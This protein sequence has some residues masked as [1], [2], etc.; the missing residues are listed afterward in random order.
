MKITNAMNI[1]H[2]GLKAAS[3]RAANSAHNVANS[4]TDGFDP[5]RVLAEDVEPGGVRTRVEKTDQPHAVYDRDGQTVE[6][7]N[8]DIAA[9]MVEQLQA[10]HAFKANIRMIQTVDSM[11]GSLLD[12]K[13]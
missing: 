10:G 11:L 2:S 1:A 12:R 5:G 8:T 7:S 13:V 6:A 9:E 3:T 4:N